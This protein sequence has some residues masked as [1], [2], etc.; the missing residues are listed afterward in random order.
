[1]SAQQTSKEAAHGVLLFLCFFV[2]SVNSPSSEYHEKVI[3]SRIREALASGKGG[4]EEIMQGT[5]APLCMC[6]DE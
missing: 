6:T 5:H 3:K 2:S 4:S 1:M